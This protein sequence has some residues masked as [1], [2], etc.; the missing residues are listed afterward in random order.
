MRHQLRVCMR[1]SCGPTPRIDVWRNKTLDRRAGLA[2][3]RP[4]RTLRRIEER[5][6]L[7]AQARRVVFIAKSRERRGAIGTFEKSL[8]LPLFTFAKRRRVQE[9]SAI[10]CIHQF[11]Q[12]L[13]RGQLS[14][15]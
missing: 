10:E 9:V 3:G 2:R 6:K 14:E 5:G 8:A 12:L 7:G 1:V 13:D 11:L 15:P 4:A